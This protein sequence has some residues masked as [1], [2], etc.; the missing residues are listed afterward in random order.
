MNKKTIAYIVIGGCLAAAG[1]YALKNS[2]EDAPA[3][4]KYLNPDI[5]Y[6]NPKESLS[7]PPAGAQAEFL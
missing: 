5:L 1:I 4:I 3:P 6:G 7:Y 2:G